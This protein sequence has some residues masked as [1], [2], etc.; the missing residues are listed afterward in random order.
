M[1]VS[2]LFFC[3]FFGGE[4]V[5][6]TDPVTWAQKANRLTFKKKD[7]F[8]FLISLDSPTPTPLPTWTGPC[9][10]TMPFKF[11]FPYK[12]GKIVWAL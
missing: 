3:L 5:F 4:V 12:K 1:I 2:L 9:F 7:I 8:F 10:I 11:F 6:E